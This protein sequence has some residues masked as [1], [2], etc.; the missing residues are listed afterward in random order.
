MSNY[1]SLCSARYEL[2]PARSLAAEKLPQGCAAFVGGTDADYPE[3]G[4][5]QRRGL[6]RHWLAVWRT[7]ADVDRF[8]SS[9]AACLPELAGAQ[10][11]T[12]LKLLPYMQRGAEVLPADSGA[13]R[14]RPDQPIAIITSIGPYASETDAISAG[15]RASLARQSLTD[16]DGLMSELLIVPF[17]PM[18]TDLFTVTTWRNEPAAQ[19]W[20]YKGPSHREAI[21]FYKTTPEK[22]RVSFTRCVIV[23]SFGV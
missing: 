8:I 22:A 17:P 23:G 14:P 4:I 18:A 19:A 6:E 16:A 9:P 21:A 15:Q 13:D 3:S 12:L 10:E 11:V 1:L 7:E 2:P 5:P 20:A